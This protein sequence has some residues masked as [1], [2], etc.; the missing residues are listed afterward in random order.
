MVFYKIKSKLFDPVFQ[1]FHN[2]I[3]AYHSSLHAPI[4]AFSNKT[5]V[6]FTHT[7]CGVCVGALFLLLAL[8]SP[9]PL[10]LEPYLFLTFAVMP[11]LLPT[12]KF[13]LPLGSQH[14]VCPSS[15]ARIT[16]WLGLQTLPMS[17]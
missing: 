6:R 11:L 4:L 12:M 2:G 7:P 15:L 16:L 8:S 1:H 3:L 17:Y 10:L 13:S 5:V 14:C 9:S